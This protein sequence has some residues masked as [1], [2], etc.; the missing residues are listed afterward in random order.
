MCFLIVADL[1]QSMRHN[2]LKMRRTERG[3]TRS[4]AEA[5]QRVVLFQCCFRFLPDVIRMALSKNLF[6]VG[7]VIFQIT[8]F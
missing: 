3:E 2:P 4:N 8:T 6:C 5:L 7:N 1:S